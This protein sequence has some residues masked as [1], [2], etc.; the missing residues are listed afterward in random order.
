MIQA[1]L[2]FARRTSTLEVAWLALWLGTFS[3]TQ[4]T[5]NESLYGGFDATHFQ[6]Y[7]FDAVALALTLLNAARLRAPRWDP[8]TLFLIYTVVG[9]LSTLWTVS[10]L[11]TLGKSGELFIGVLIVWITMARR[12]PLLRLRRLID[13]SALFLGF[14]LML[15]FLGFVLF[16]EQ[17]SIPSPGVLSRQM[18]TPFIASNGIAN[19]AAALGLL[20]L[21]RFLTGPRAGGRA[22]IMRSG[23]LWL[24]LFFAILPVLAQGRTGQSVFL[25]GSM[26]LLLR[27]RPGVALLLVIPPIIL[28]VTAFMGEISSFFVRGQQ[29]AQ[30]LGLSGRL[31]LWQWAWS[32]FLDDPIFGAGF[33]VGSRAMFAGGTGG[34]GALISSVHNGFFEVLLSTGLVGLVFWLPSF[35]WGIGIAV[36]AYLRGE[37]LDVAILFTYLIATTIMSIGVG[38]WMGPGP[39]FFLAAVSYLHLA[40][41]RARAP[42]RR[43]PVGRP[44]P[45]PPPRPSPGLARGR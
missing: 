28:I 14:L 33:G 13:W 4:R 34:F 17:F 1:F 23:Y 38:G 10:L 39:A 45:R 8:T 19:G 22:R 11:P 16:T 27:R 18:D 6:R 15:A 30:L 26:L 21:A 12:E 36:A 43:H 41:R 25:S 35:L 44:P 2:T 40:R 20:C 24:T 3:F 7:M 5:A 42:D 9:L 29:E 32:T 31:I 37:H